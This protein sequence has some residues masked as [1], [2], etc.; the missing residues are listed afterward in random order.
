MEA[1]GSRM[2]G[3]VSSSGSVRSPTATNAPSV[4]HDKSSQQGEVEFF[5]TAASKAALIEGSAEAG[6]N[7]GIPATEPIRVA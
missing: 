7:L 4:V 2:R 1:L 6:R 3:S 5:G